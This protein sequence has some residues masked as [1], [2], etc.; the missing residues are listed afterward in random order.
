MKSSVF[1]KQLLEKLNT[2]LKPRRFKK[3]QNIFSFSNKDLTY[4]ICVQNRNDSTADSLNTTVNIEIASSKLTYLDDMSIPG[5]LQ[6]HYVKNIGDYAGLN[7][8]K[9][10]T[11]DTEESALRAQQEIAEIITS[12]VLP[13]IDQLK[14][15]NDLA[16]LW[17][18]HISPGLTQYQSREYLSL[19]Q[20][21]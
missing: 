20:M 10:W 14:S 6:R 18:K 21:V 1:K 19:L 17:K 16:S 8:E 15:T 11:I 2:V 5:Y 12:K 3:S 4:F 7:Q 13:E 9:W